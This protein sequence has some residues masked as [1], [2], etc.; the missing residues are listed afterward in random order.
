ME[1]DPARSE[2]RATPVPTASG[3]S[4]WPGRSPG[5]GDAKSR[6]PRCENDG[7]QAIDLAV[8]GHA[9]V[10]ARNLVVVAFVG[11]ACVPVDDFVRAGIERA[12]VYAA[13]KARVDRFSKTAM[14]LIRPALRRAVVK[15]LP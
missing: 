9:G 4:D 1:P 12:E 11:D 8:D 5:C 2:G 15:C 14:T 13:R 10:A 7:E 6:S 3:S